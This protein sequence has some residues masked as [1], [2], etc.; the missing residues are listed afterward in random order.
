VY[1][2]INPFSL[3]KNVIFLYS[4]DINIDCNMYKIIA[5]DNQ[6]ETYNLA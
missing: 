3:K 5:L 1:I 2:N 6:L 4:K